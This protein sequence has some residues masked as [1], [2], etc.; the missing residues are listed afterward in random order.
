MSV[1]STSTERLSLTECLDIR[2]SSLQFNANFLGTL[3][4]EEGRAKARIQDGEL[5][6]RASAEI[7]RLEAEVAR[8]SAGTIAQN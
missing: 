3:G 2:G 5:M 6:S 8:L 4:T 1:A 7:K